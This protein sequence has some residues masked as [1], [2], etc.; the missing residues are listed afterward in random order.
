MSFLSRLSENHKARQRLWW[1]AYAAASAAATVTGA[2]GSRR[3]AAATKPIPL[4]LLGIRVVE[5]PHL[6]RLD[7]VLVSGALAASAIGDVW[8]YREEFADD[9]DDK[10]RY[11]QI[12]AASFG[13]AQGFYSA[14]MIRRGGRFRPAALAPRLVV[15]GEPAA[16]LAKFRP[17]VLPVLGPYGSTLATM[18]A[19]ASTT[20][21]KRLTAGGIT[22]QASDIAIINRRH[23]LR[24][25]DPRAAGARKAVEAWVLGSYFAAQLLLV[26]GLLRPD[27]KSDY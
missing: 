10:D 5:H 13:V 14:S 12:G 16:I 3:A 22:F 11:L 6:T 27:S 1:A 26:D 8:M 23:L 15:M 9:A 21:S 7:R 24:A 20:G 19:L 25:D 18:S 4:A 2:L 17:R